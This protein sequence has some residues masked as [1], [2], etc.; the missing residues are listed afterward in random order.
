MGASGMPL[1]MHTCVFLSAP[2][3]PPRISGGGMGASGM[4]LTCSGHPLSMNGARGYLAE[5]PLR[6]PVRGSMF[7]HS[8]I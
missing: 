2:P 1:H 8:A 5:L 4:P 6:M 3:P 7:G